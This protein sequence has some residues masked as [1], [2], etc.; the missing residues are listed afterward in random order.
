MLSWF[1]LRGGI[2]ESNFSTTFVKYVQKPPAIVRNQHGTLTPKETL[3]KL[4]WFNTGLQDLYTINDYSRTSHVTPMIQQLGWDTLEH[5]RLLAQLIMFY[6]INQDMVGLN[7]P[8]EVSPL[9]RRQSSRLPN[10]QSFNHIQTN[11]DAY[12]FS[13]FPRT[14]VTWNHVPLT[15]YTPTVSAFKEAAMSFV[16]SH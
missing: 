14:I 2:P 3:T 9:F 15:N 1:Q 13:F 6:K 16:R 10:P 8:S 11:I 5:R 12:K 4:K 7:F